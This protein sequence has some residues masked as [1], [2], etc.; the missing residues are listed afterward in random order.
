MKKKFTLFAGS[1]LVLAILLPET[2][3][4]QQITYEAELELLAGEQDK[5]SIEKVQLHKDGTLTILGLGQRLGQ[6]LKPGEEIAYKNG[7]ATAYYPAL[8]KYHL[9]ESLQLKSKV[10]ENYHLSSLS[11][12]EEDPSPYL[13]INSANEILGESKT[14]K[15]F[16]RL[17]A[18]YPEIYARQKPEK[19]SY[20]MAEYM[21]A[22]PL[23][24]HTTVSYRYELLSNSFPGTRREEIVPL[25]FP[26]EDR[27]ILYVHDRIKIHERAGLVSMVSGLKQDDEQSYAHYRNQHLRLYSLK[28]SL[29]SQYAL[30]FDYPSEMR[31][32]EFVTDQAGQEAGI[33]YVFGAARRYGKQYT[34]PDPTNYEI[35]YLDSGQKEKFRH[36]YRYG[37]AH[38]ASE[39]FFATVNKEQL[40]VLGKGVGKEP[41]FHLLIFDKDGLK[42]TTRIDQS[43]FYENNVGDYK[44]GLGQGY[45]SQYLVAGSKV[46]ADG[47]IVFFGEHRT[48]KTPAGHVL[49]A[50]RQSTAAY[51][52]HSYVFLHFN[53]AGDLMGNYVLERAENN[54]SSR[55]ARIEL[56]S[57]EKG[58][59][60]LMVVEPGSDGPR[61]A[62]PRPVAGGLSGSAKGELADRAALAT[63][64]PEEKDIDTGRES[65]SYPDRQSISAVV[66]IDVVNRALNVLR[67][68]DGFHILNEH[69]LLHDPLRKELVLVGTSANKHALQRLIIK[70]IKL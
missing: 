34:D 9:S 21:L 4:A 16:D 13:L 7:G 55:S 61:Q 35:V 32:H 49:Q 65:K 67:M 31:L 29:L 52:Y 62:G 48:L 69:G 23:L 14:D 10:Q 24:A 40:L 41:D 66:S 26:A 2:A 68:S 63:G 22:G 17:Q 20:N 27:K 60:Q 57:A 37:S 11:G 64:Y 30:A 50:D 33:V 19:H 42:K 36:K 43:V 70:K 51:E 44:S 46:L 39:P 38:T 54:C 3:P 28:G 6:L 47:S 8:L 15:T 1:L 5:I 18:E 12:P 59:L 58:K 56:L 53:P 45:A 25:Q